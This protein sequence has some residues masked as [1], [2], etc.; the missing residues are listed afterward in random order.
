MAK[1]RINKNISLIILIGLLLLIAGCS[2]NAQA[3]Q[4]TVPAQNPYVGQGCAVSGIDTTEKQEIIY[5]Q[6]YI[7]L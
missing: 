6:G 4:N 2:S 1:Q 3:P 7:N 5:T